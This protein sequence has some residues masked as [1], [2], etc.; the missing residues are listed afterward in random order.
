MNDGLPGDL[1]LRHPRGETALFVGR[2]AFERGRPHLGAWL[3]GRQAFLVSSEAVLA[4]HR[5]V[6]AEI[7]K[8]CADLVVL[9]VPDG[10]S[11]KSLA[12]A[13]SVWRQ[14]LRA[15]A[16]R[17]S[18]LLGLGGGSVGDLTGFVAATF[19]RGIEMALLPTSLLAQVDAAIGG[20]AAIDLPAAKNAVGAFW[21]P[22]WV[23]A[24]LDW[25]GSLPERELRAGLAEVVKIAAAAD[26]PL[27]ERLERDLPA[28]LAGDLERLDATVRSAAAVKVRIVEADPDEADR[29][30]LLNLGH[31]LAH[32]I[33]TASEYRGLRHG[34]AVAYGLLFATRLARAR[35]AD[36]RF[37]DR[38]AALVSALAPPP[39]PTLSVEALQDAMRRDKKARREGVVWVLPMRVGEIEL[40]ADLDPAMLRAELEA[41][42]SAPWEGFS[43][44]ADGVR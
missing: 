35:G 23:V 10:E 12:V 27:F 19:L 24:D 14:M 4:H 28:C 31:T 13:E 9:P 18:L 29:R 11:A 5:P 17:D 44:A 36:E 20:K 43:R 16:R 42:L 38:L 40:V 26:A 3:S 39:L 25:L 6:C 33:E 7:E 32:A 41:F 15:E 8:L 22:R 30:R 1:T 21:H 2:G 34:E 37:G